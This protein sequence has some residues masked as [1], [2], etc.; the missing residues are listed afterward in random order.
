VSADWVLNGAIAIIVVIAIAANPLWRTIVIESIAH[1]R[2]RSEISRDGA[3]V[4]RHA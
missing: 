3:D 2:R 4:R 1:P